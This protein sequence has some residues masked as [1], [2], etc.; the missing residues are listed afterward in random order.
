MNYQ[1]IYNDL[2][3]YAKGQKLSIGQYVEVHHI[4]PKSLDGTDDNANLITLTARQHYIAHM[5]LVKIAEEHNNLQ[6]YK[7][8][9]YAFNCMKWGRVDGKRIFKYNSRLYQKLK[10]K[11][12]ALRII[13]M[14]SKNPMSGKIWIC[15]F[16]LEESKIWD[17]NLP[18]PNGWI[19][20]RHSKKQ[21][22]KLKKQILQKDILMQ[23]AIEEKEKKLKLLYAMFEEFK[24]N[25]F[26][27]VVKKFGYTHTRNNLIMAFKANIPEYVPQQCNRWKNQK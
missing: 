2:I 17:S 5:L 22:K 6:E 26:D 21:F 7:K 18:I 16:E 19:K 14:S 3:Q 9:L 23:K 15:N 13:A 8:M 10:E 1:K 4:I 20:G 27:G 25:E 12:S 11:F 24:K